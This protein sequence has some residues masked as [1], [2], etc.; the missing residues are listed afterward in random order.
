[1]GAAGYLFPTHNVHHSGG[2]H[3]SQVHVMQHPHHQQQQLHQAMQQS[4]QPHGHSMNL[5][6]A[7]GGDGYSDPE[8][9]SPTSLPPTSLSPT[10][11]PPASLSSVVPPSPSHSSSSSSSSVEDRGK[12]KVNVILLH[13]PRG[14]KGVWHPIAQGDHIR[15][16][17]GK[18]KRLK[19]E[20]R[21]NVELAQDVVVSLVLDGGAQVLSSGSD[22]GLVVESIRS[23]PPAP[24]TPPAT[25]PSSSAGVYVTE[26]SLKLSR[27]SRRLAI[28]VRTKIRD[29]PSSMLEARSIEFSAHNNGKERYFYSPPYSIIGIYLF[30]NLFSTIHGSGGVR[31]GS[32]TQAATSSTTYTQ[33]ISPTKTEPKTLPSPRNSLNNS[34]TILPPSPHDVIYPKGSSACN[35]YV[36]P[37]V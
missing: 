31:P 13:K 5:S 15:V 34:D 23:L 37:N 32:P 7:V 18:G 30:I 35:V 26:L 25:P 6:I 17:K 10:S 14:S 2:V 29:N 4:I 19:L 11:L 3:P 16:T 1:M 21:S 8:A 36:K 28:M 33:S 22:S 20:V 27:L 24:A 9:L 12:G